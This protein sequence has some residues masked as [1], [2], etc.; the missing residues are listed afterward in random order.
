[1]ENKN[2]KRSLLR[3][4]IL[5]TLLMCST[6]AYLEAS[7]E[8]SIDNYLE[9]SEKE[10]T[11][12]QGEIKEYHCSC[13]KC[14][15]LTELDKERKEVRA[16]LC[17]VSL[18][19]TIGLSLI[20]YYKNNRHLR[21][22]GINILSSVMALYSSY[23]LATRLRADGFA[24]LNASCMTMLLSITFICIIYEVCQSG[25]YMIRKID[26]SVVLFWIFNLY[27]MLTRLSRIVFELAPYIKT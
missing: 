16:N 24:I 13:D 11:N 18:A 26:Y 14:H 7:S 3:F 19:T 27:E 15:T 23:Q 20:N 25:E 9:E 1:M 5:I 10:I 8:I 22:N 21:I 12:H 17:I 2:K 6:C 4:L